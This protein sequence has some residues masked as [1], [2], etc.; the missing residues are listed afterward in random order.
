MRKINPKDIIYFV[1][2]SQLLN[3]QARHNLQDFCK[4]HEIIPHDVRSDIFCH[5]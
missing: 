4:I 3:P 2:D 1:Y 5:Y